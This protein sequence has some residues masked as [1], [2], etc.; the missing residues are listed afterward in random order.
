MK[1]ENVCQKQFNKTQ[2]KQF[3]NL[4]GHHN[5]QTF[6]KQAFQYAIC[7]REYSSHVIFT[8]YNFWTS[9]L[10]TEKNFSI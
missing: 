8:L 10:A 4:K 2:N 1:Q 7:F 6:L 9:F 3:C 5:K